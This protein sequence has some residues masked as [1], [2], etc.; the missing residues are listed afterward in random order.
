ML[1]SAPSWEMEDAIMRPPAAKAL[2][3]AITEED[4]EYLSEI[5]GQHRLDVSARSGDDDEGDNSDGDYEEVNFEDADEEAALSDDADTVTSKNPGFV[6]ALLDSAIPLDLR[7]NTF[8]I[9]KGDYRIEKKTLLHHA[10]TSDQYD[11]FSQ[12]RKPFKRS[13]TNPPKTAP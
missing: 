2:E 13:N 1:A 5:S 12:R 11:I 4:E 9:V 10:A 7:D 6:R 3:D 8:G